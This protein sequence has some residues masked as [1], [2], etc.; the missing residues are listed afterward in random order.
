MDLKAWEQQE[1]QRK[2]NVQYKVYP[3]N[4]EDAKDPNDDLTMSIIAQRVGHML[5]KK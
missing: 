3:A 1:P 4:S 2:K 5:Y